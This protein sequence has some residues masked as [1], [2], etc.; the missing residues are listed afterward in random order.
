MVS[1]MR[2]VTKGG[3]EGEQGEQDEEE[4]EESEESEE[5]EEEEGEVA[6]KGADPDYQ[7]EMIQARHLQLRQAKYLLLQARHRTNYLISVHSACRLL[8]APLSR[9]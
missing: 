4:C 1:L 8:V 7:D 2:I 5:S 3:E 6:G 9:L